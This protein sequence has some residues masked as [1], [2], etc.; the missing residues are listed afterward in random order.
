MKLTMKVQIAGSRNGVR[1][2]EAG[3][4]VDLPEN[5]A[6]E[7]IAAKLAVPFE[8]DEDEPVEEPVEVVEPEGECHPEC[9]PECTPPT[10]HVLTV[11]EPVVEAET[12][13]DSPEAENA[14]ENDAQP[15]E[16]AEERTA[17]EPETRPARPANKRNRR[18]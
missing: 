14:P 9:S 10:E 13:E 5:E 18:R 4:T 16:E 3:E 17:P 7:L 1:W 15:V 6:N 11:E 2:P 12:T 8:G